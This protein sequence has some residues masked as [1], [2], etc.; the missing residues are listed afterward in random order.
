MN[1]K[2]KDFQRRAYKHKS[3]LICKDCGKDIFENPVDYFMVT[4]ELWE[5][6]GVGKGLLCLDCF[7]KRLGRPLVKEDIK[8]CELN[9]EWNPYT[10]KLLD[11]K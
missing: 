6:Y 1:K 7:E 8:I 5:Q 4:D 11:I 2:N 10:R 9:I 3:S